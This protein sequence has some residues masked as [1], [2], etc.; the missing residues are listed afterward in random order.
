MAQRIKEVSQYKNG[1]WNAAVPIGADA[2]NIDVNL[3]NGG[4]TD[5]QSLLGVNSASPA[6]QTIQGQLNQF[7]KIYKSTENP[8]SADGNNGDLWL[9]Y[10]DPSL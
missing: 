1:A 3:L 5:L 2:D 10:I 8:T 9:V 6:A 7:T 4:T